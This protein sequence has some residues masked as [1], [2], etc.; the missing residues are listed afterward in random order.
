MP[1][2]ALPELQGRARGDGE[3]HVHGVLPH[4]GGERAA[5]RPHHV[6]DR[7]LRLPD[8]AVDR[9]LDGRVV[10]VDLRGAEVGLC[11]EELPREVA[12]VGLGGVDVG[13]LARRGVEQG[14]GA[15]QVDVRV[16]EL[17]L[18]LLHR[19]ALGVDIGLEGRLLEPVE[20]VPR[21][22]LA[23]FREVDMLQI[24]RDAGH[25]VDGVDGLDAT[26]EV[27]GLGDGLQPH[28]GDADRGR[29]ARARGLG[30]P[31]IAAHR[32]G[33][34]EQHA[35]GETSRCEGADRG[36]SAIGS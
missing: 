15:L 30:P 13:L 33:C 5:A 10:E 31:R 8:L 21:L 24:G 20:R 25:E 11:G 14:L 4:N 34:H 16:G 3:Q 32:A 1:H 36:P 2:V 26:D 23:A 12:L 29:R 18:D 7:D 35:Q 19:A 9:G 22:H 27:L 6:A 17:R 28:L